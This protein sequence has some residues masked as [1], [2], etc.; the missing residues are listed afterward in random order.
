MQP[1]QLF[2][3]IRAYC[4][5]HQNEAIVSK[6][7]RYFKEGYDAYGL[8]QELVEEKSKAIL[9][10]PE[11][12]LGFVLSTSRLLIASG[13]YEETSFAY[14]LTKSFIKEF[15]RTTFDEIQEWFSI[16]IINWAHTDVIGSELLTHF[17]REQIVS[18]KDFECW[19]LAGN[20]FQR[21]AVPVAFIKPFKEGYALKPLLDFVDAL[22]LDQERVVH[23]GL[24]WFL[25]ECWKKQ[26]QP[27]EAFLHKWKNDAA[28][29]I[30]QYATEKMSKEYRQQ[31]R[32]ERKKSR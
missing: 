7:A 14:L 4:L 29:L 15:D 19:R 22:M 17:V 12:N 10:Q 18:L 5:L 27:V 26:P 16:G 30:F 11:V 8:S 31:F 2:E 21:R 13:K 9:S 28:R 24:G 25:R 1:Q 20:K 23:Q 32:K 3:D 6:Y